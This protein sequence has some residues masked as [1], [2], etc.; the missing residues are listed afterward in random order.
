MIDNEV[1]WKAVLERDATHDGRFFYGVLTTGVYCRPSCPSRKPLSRNVRFYGSE[2]EAERAGLRP[3]LRCGPAASQGR[4]NRVKIER[5]CEFIQGNCNQPESISLTELS[6][7]ACL[8]PFHL[9]RLFKQ[10][11]GV[12][13]KEYAESCRI[14]DFKSQLRERGSVTEAIYEAGFS[15]SSRAYE[16]VDSKLG[17]TPAEYKIGGKGIQISYVFA[18]SPLGAMMIGATDRGLC[19]LQFADCAEELFARLQAEYPFASLQETNEPY[20]ELL[21]QAM[22]ALHRYLQNEQPRLDL[23]L[24]VRATAFQLRVW[25]YLQSIPYGQVQSYSEIAA[26]LDQPGAARA[27]ARA[28]ASNRV[29]IAIPCHRVIRGDGGLGGFKWGLDRKRILLEAERTGQ[30]TS[31]DP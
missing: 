30:L 10:V 31:L 4:V 19:F 18:E 8:S 20:P 1:C 17:M 16:R 25:K 6:R 27:V 14:S 23:P 11:V 9:Q 2:V 7:Q 22:D 3:C 26:A 21:G 24:D 5:L 29:A 12:S 15:S 28:C 13:P